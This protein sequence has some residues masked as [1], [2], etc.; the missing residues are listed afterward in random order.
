MEIPAAATSG[1]LWKNV[2]LEILQENSQEN[3]YTRV[4]FW[5]KETLSLLKKDSDRGV[6]CEISRNTFSE[7]Y[8][9]I[10]VV[11]VN[12]H[13]MIKFAP[14]ATTGFYPVP[15]LFESHCIDISHG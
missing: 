1:V 5:I 9:K 7:I 4:S 14:L 2:L 12:I 15:K 6:F 13:L 11:L 3:T 10:K 8:D